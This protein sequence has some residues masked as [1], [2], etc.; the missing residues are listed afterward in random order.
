MKRREFIASAA[1]LSLAGTL[2]DCSANPDS[3]AMNNSYDVIVL[4]V[5]TMGS[6]TCYHLASRGLKVLGLE[7]FDIAHDQGSHAGQSRIIRKAYFEHHDYVPLL[8]RA[9]ENWAAL[10]KETGT[11]LYFKTGLFYMGKPD[12]DIIKGVKKSSELYK[13]PVEELTRAQ[14]A[15]RFPQFAVPEGFNVL[16]EPEAG[17]ITPERAILAYTQAAIAKGAHIFT[18]VR[19]NG[20]DQKNDNITVSTSAGTFTAGRIV[21]TAG[22]WTSKLVNLKTELK[23]TRQTVVWW[24]TPHLRK[25]DFGKFPCWINEDP[26]RGSFY[27]FPVLDAGKFGGPIGLKMAHHYPQMPVDPDKVDRQVTQDYLDDIIAYA[28]EFMPD[29]EGPPFSVKTCL[30]TYSKDENFIIDHVPGSGKRVTIACGF[31]G[32][33]FKFASVIGEVLADMSMK[34]KTDLPVG[35]LSLS[36]FNNQG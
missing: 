3:K 33:G 23:P 21:I 12:A 8:E 11:T 2:V 10:E 14:S 16:F 20:W 15:T 32:H 25:F 4:G 24:N 1:G 22:A 35:F 36:R 19:V 34:G 13:V 30:Y 26:K 31:S 18:K 9:Y 27:G 28:R 5:G 7:Q 17:F 6:A 29:A